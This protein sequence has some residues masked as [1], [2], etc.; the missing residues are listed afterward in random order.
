MKLDLSEI[1]AQVGKRITYEIDEPPAEDLA[2]GLRCVERI[3]GEATFTN[4]G[5]NIVARGSFR[6]VVELEC[7]RCLSRYRVDLQIPIQEELPLA[8]HAPAAEDE[9][10]DELPEEETEP[11][12]EHNVFDLRELLRQLLLVAIPIGPLCSEACQGL[13]PQCGKNLNEGPCD[14]TLDEVTSPFSAL[15]ALLDDEDKAS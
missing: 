5:S 4:T 10:E 3:A 9:D 6:T 8:G 14:C 2:G 13:C 12:F 11:L 7:G 15:G 1:A